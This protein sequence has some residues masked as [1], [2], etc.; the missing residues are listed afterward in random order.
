MKSPLNDFILDLLNFRKDPKVLEKKLDQ[1]REEY[2]AEKQKLEEQKLAYLHAFEQPREEYQNAL[3]TYLD[4]LTYLRSLY[5]KKPTH[6]GALHT[7]LKESTNFPEVLKNKPAGTF[8]Y[9]P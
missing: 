3:T 1:L 8:S 5:A 6:K 4:N 7:W 2:F 9:L